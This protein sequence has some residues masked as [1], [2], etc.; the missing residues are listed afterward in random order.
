MRPRLMVFDFDGTLAETRQAVSDTV[1][2][3]L[4]ARN[5]PRVEPAFIHGL[6]GLPLDVLLLRL[7]PPHRKPFDVAPL[8]V[9]Y[10]AR[11]D[12]I[13]ATSVGPMPHAAELLDALAGAGVRV[14]IATSR[15][16]ASLL[17]LLDRLEL[18]S[19][20]ELAVT[21]EEV[22]QGKPHPEM[23][24]AVLS[25]AGVATDEAWMVGDTTWDVQMGI[26]AGLRTFGV[27][28]CHTAEALGAAGGEV[29]AD[30]AGLRA[31]W[32]EA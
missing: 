26:A 15:E 17:R 5:L 20:V 12:E 18:A 1:N 13:A 19:K 3:V 11:F 6:M 27:P 2:A 8:V 29:V 30:L 25:R 24:H 4:F 9:D 16:R 21:G 31:R 28:G 23:L 14:A 22:S 7:I 32:A 10:R